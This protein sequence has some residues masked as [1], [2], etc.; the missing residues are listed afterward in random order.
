MKGEARWTIAPST[1][2]VPAQMSATVSNSKSPFR[3]GSITCE[4]QHSP[5]RAQRKP[6]EFFRHRQENRFEGSAFFAFSAVRLNGYKR[7]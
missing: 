1:V 6:V 4:G 5:P 2:Y 3:S 7:G